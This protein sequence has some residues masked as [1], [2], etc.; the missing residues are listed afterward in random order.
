MLTFSIFWKKYANRRG[1]DF[2]IFFCSDKGGS[3]YH[4]NIDSQYKANRKIGYVDLPDYYT[5]LVNIRRQNFE[6]AEKLLNKIP[7]MNVFLLKFLESDF[8]P[9]YVI[10][11]HYP[12]DN[13][14]NIVLSNDKDVYQACF[15]ENT[16]MLYKNRGTTFL[17]DKNTVVGKYLGVDK[18]SQ[19]IKEK[20]VKELR[21]FDME[22]LAAMMA[23][24]GDAGDG[25]PGIK[26]IG[27]VAAFKL[28]QDKEIVNTLIGSPQKLVERVVLNHGSF[29][30]VDRVSDL[31]SIDV[32]KVWNK[33]IENNDLVT[34][35]FKMISFEALSTWVDKGPEL[36]C[37]EH[38]KYIED[39][40][41]SSKYGTSNSPRV[42]VES[43]K[44]LPDLNFDI[45][46][47]EVLY[48]R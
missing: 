41:D 24:I 27:P 46:E 14:L 5:D 20:R 23:I 43:L 16:F 6:L 7:C 48:E 2:E 37:S 34:R 33:V 45:E 26:G 17:L 18:A 4:T 30:D 3:V 15:G 28:F 47:I 21:E 11:R 8:L 44:R 40:L 35:A 10:D 29:I 36:K 13:I 1:L 19:K 31:S 38:K 25:I 39:I 22:Y 32:S 42:L 9:Y 12:D